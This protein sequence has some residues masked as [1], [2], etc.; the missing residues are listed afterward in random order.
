M[1]T[2]IKI[3]TVSSSF[4]RYEG[5]SA[6]RR[7]YDLVNILASEY[8]IHVIYLNYPS[9][10]Q[11]NGKVHSLYH[12]HPIRYPCKAY[13][14]A[15]VG[16]L[17]SLKLIP[18]FVNMLAQIRKIV[19]QYDINLIHAHW[20]IPSGFLAALAC[21]NIPLITTLRGLDVKVSGKQRM[22]QLPVKYALK[23]ST[24]IV[25]LS[26]KLKQEAIDAGAEVDKIH[27]IPGGVD[28][29]KFKPL[30][31][32]AT[33]ARFN[34][35]E[36]FLIIFVGNLIKLKGVDRLIRISAKLSRDFSFHLLIVGDGPERV[37]LENMSTDLKLETIRFTGRISHDDMPFYMA[38]ADVL[39]LLS[40][41]EGLPGCVQE[42]MA[43][44]VP[45][46]ANNVGGLPDLIS[47][48][49]NGYLVN[50]DEET[51]ERLRTLISSPE[52]RT[53][54]GACALEFARKNLSLDTVAEQTH[55]LYKSIMEKQ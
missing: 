20:A 19:K 12:P 5:D 42:A 53:S 43:C 29:K 6:G 26:N 9:I 55:D 39:I 22:F 24:R 44:G 32:H 50:S 18:T 28:I 15:E 33:R 27:V 10:I 54:M 21:S 13:S 46:I 41:S 31:K 52:K 23:K 16:L 35:P 25:A 8:R 2:T 47:D 17:E 36:G 49:T 1:N 45:V 48:G 37:N 40:E 51:E 38:A 14:L 4:P 7:V 11:D 30:D 3:C 34:L